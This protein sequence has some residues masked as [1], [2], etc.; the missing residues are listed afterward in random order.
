MTIDQ[1][2]LTFTPYRIGDQTEFEPVHGSQIPFG[3]LK[4]YISKPVWFYALDPLDKR[5]MWKLLEVY[6]FRKFYPLS[7]SVVI[8][9]SYKDATYK[10]THYDW[11]HGGPYNKFY[12]VI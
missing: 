2:N 12:E 1:F 9:I 10:I 4:H 3:K 8:L 6:Q 11:E 7:D 5:P